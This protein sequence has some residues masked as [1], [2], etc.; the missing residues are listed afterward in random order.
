MTEVHLICKNCILVDG[1]LGIE[2][3]KDQLCDFCADPTHKNPNWSKRE[4]KNEQRKDKLNDWNQTLKEMQR[5]HKGSCYDCV[6]GYSGGK[7]STSLVDTFVNEYHLNPLLVSVDTGFMTEVAKQNMKDTLNKINMFENHILIED[8]IPTFKKL[9]YHYFFNH[10]SPEKALTVE[11]CH[12]CTDLIHTIVFKETLKRN[13]PYVIIGF[14]P[15]QIARYFYE[16]PLEGIIADGSP[17]NIFNEE[18]S[19]LKWYLNQEDKEKMQ[20]KCPRLLYPYHVMDYDEQE[21]ISR[22]EVKELI[23]KGK[24]DPILTNCHV[25]KAA[26]FHDF[27]RYGVVTYALQYAELI[28][29]EKDPIKRKKSRKSWL[30]AYKQI[31]KGILNARFNPEG[32]ESFLTTLGTTREELLQKIIEKRQ[33]DDNESKILQ[34][35]ERIVL[36]KLK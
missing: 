5:A 14:S 8:A 10:N 13:I 32:I 12:K 27:Y 4:I 21:I 22:L 2:I 16:T 7:D 31:A 26:L 34:N 15:D 1:F 35:I 24:G 23:Q 36:N 29:Q 25:V 33:S 11:I 3:N 28:R 18:E 19:D 17:L 6:I 30:R 9:Y 20:I